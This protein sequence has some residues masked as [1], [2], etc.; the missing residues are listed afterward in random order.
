[1]LRITFKIFQ[2]VCKAHRH[3]EGFKD[4]SLEL[5][6]SLTFSRKETIR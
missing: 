1:M 2:E 5:S 3:L 6:Q 4:G